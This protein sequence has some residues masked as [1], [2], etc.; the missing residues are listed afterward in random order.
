MAFVYELLG[1]RDKALQVITSMKDMGIPVDLRHPV[2][3]DLKQDRNY[4][5]LSPYATVR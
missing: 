5:A 4:L 3:E 1:M 2:F